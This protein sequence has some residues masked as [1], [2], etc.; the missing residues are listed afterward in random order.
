MNSER[1]EIDDKMTL[2]RRFSLHIEDD[3]KVELQGL[4]ARRP[5]TLASGSPRRKQILRLAG[6]EPKVVVPSVKEN[7]NG[8]ESPRDYAIRLAELKLKSVMADD[9]LTVA[10]DTIVV[11]GD[12]I[13]GKP[14]DNLDA[15]RI[16]RFLSGRRHW[17]MT[18]LA[19]RDG[20]SDKIVSD[21][22]T[23]FVTFN[24]LKVSDIKSYVD[25]GEPMDKAGAYGIQGMGELLVQKLEGSLLNVIGFP[26]ELF[27]RMLR[28]LRK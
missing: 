3:L 11:L 6:I 25:S 12:T 23:S 9:S 16:L 1:I 19:I 18:S 7:L 5:V 21:G 4:I 24:D 22:D 17:V 28:D 8:I 10:A 13:L 15:R 27:V 14:V 20:R 26:I 2:Q